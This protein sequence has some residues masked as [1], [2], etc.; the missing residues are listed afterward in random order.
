MPGTG[1]KPDAPGEEIGPLV[2][3]VGGFL[4]DVAR[5][6]AGVVRDPRVPAIAKVQAAALLGLG[7]SPIDAIPFIGQLEMVGAIGLAARQLLKHTTPEV[8]REHWTGNDEGFRAVMMVVDV[9][10][11]PSRLAMRLLGFG[12][13]SED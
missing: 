6:F 5:M 12:R 11:R 8:L 10:L 3:M 7:L 1:P 4:P 2:R 13:R 9:G